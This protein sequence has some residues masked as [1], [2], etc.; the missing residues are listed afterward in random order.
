M[1]FIF[2]ILISSH[3][4]IS[5]P[6]VIVLPRASPREWAPTYTPWGPE[7]EAN[8]TLEARQLGSSDTKPFLV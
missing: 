6:G 3:L 4:R 2:C 1:S 5:D 8:G 7:N